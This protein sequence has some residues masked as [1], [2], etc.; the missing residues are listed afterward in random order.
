MKQP[1]CG[2]PNVTA[3]PNQVI[4]LP[5]IAV[6]LNLAQHAWNNNKGRGDVCHPAQDPG[7]QGSIG[8]SR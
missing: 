2:H 8:R 6:S 3:D 7:D 1:Q 4:I 5:R